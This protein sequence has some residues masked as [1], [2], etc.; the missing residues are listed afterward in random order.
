MSHGPRKKSV[1]FGGNPAHVTLGL[2]GGTIVV[3]ILK[4][5]GGTANSAWEGIIMSPG[6]RGQGHWTSK[7]QNLFLRITQFNYYHRE[8]RRKLRVAYSILEI[9][10]NMTVA[11]VRD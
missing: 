4:Y 6:S 9:F 2:C 10:L 7:S 8:S 5:Y 3:Y 11:G 1:D